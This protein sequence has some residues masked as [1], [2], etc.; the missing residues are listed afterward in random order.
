MDAYRETLLYHLGVLEERWRLLAW[1][2]IVVAGILAAVAAYAVS[3]HF[4]NM[5]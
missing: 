4:M 1:L 3:L 5:G 2:L